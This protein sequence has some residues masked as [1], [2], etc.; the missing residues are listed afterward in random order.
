MPLILEEPSPEQL[1][2]SGD[3]AGLLTKLG[4]LWYCSQN[5]HENN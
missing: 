1:L 4:K 5:L 2:I 3:L